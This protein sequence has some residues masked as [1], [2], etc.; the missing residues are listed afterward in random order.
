M[1]VLG[2]VIHR[3]KPSRLH[4]SKGNDLFATFLSLYLVS[5]GR[6][7]RWKGKKINRQRSLGRSVRK[8]GLALT[9]LLEQ[10]P[11]DSGKVGKTGKP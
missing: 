7:S 9:L 11:S 6:N 5:K 10:A 2:K 3:L 8:P 4:K 1:L